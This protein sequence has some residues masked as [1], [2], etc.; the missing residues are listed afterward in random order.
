[1]TIGSAGRRGARPDHPRVP[2]PQR[3]ALPSAL[4]LEFDVAEP[5]IEELTEGDPRELVLENARWKAA[6]VAAKAKPGT[7]VIGG[8][9][10]VVSTA[11]C[12]GSPRTRRGSPAPGALFREGPRGARRIGA[13]RA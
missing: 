11:R 9:T 2:I 6:A 10:E 5:A 13:A 4:G 8:D 12:S 3:Q 7:V 1:M